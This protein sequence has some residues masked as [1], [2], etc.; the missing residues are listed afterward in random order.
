MAGALKF[1]IFAS[2]FVSLFLPFGTNLCWCL[3]ILVFIIKLLAVSLI[4]GWIELNTAK[5][6]LFKVPNLLGMAIVFSF[7]SL[8]IYYI[9]GA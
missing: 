6:R 2:L 1:G 7:L 4:V 5:L 8:I 9:V 3:A